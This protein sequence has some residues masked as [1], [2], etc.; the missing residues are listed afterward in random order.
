MERA[1]R[2]PSPSSG[3]LVCLPGLFA[4]S[5]GNCPAQANVELATVVSWGAGLFWASV[6]DLCSSRALD[7]P[8]RATGPQAQTRA[9]VLMALWQEVSSALVFYQHLMKS[10]SE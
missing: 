10:L 3:F 8:L 4:W 1:R 7:L 9:T 2:C 6:R 5:C